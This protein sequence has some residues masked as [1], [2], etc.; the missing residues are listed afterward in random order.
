MNTKTKRIMFGKEFRDGGFKE[1][2]DSLPYNK[3][4]E[5]RDEIC[6]LC[7]WNINIFGTKI[8][9][10]VAFRIYEIEKIESFFKTYNIN[11]WTGEK[12]TA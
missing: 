11:A 3:R 1:A 10:R 2:F 12:L 7:Y 5:A 6:K 4:M 8:T 9:G